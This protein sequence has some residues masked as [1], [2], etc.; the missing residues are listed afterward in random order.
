M[1]D[2][3]LNTYLNDWDL[4]FS[5]R[6]Q[7]LNLTLEVKG[8]KTKFAEYGPIHVKFGVDYFDCCW[9]IKFLNFVMVSKVEF[10][11]RGQRPKDK[12]S[13]KSTNKDTCKIL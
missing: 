7:R 13:G 5:F 3:C 8:H 10:D 6:P 4:K 12:Q 9:V 11:L 1:S 2:N